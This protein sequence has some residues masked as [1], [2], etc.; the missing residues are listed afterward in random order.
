MRYD[1]YIFA[2][3]PGKC[4]NIIEKVEGLS[5]IGRDSPGT[6]FFFLCCVTLSHWPWGVSMIPNIHSLA[7]YCERCSWGEIFFWS[8]CSLEPVC[9][10]PA[11][12]CDTRYH[13]LTRFTAEK[14]HMFFLG[15]H[16][17]SELKTCLNP[18]PKKKLIQDGDKKKKASSG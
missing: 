6:F 13:R 18:P 4:L 12:Y 9:R 16:T 7:K 17:L 10:C 8:C 1:F 11:V 15:S 14:N 3:A 2:P 5:L